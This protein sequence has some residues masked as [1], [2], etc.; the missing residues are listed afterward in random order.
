[1]I[2]SNLVPLNFFKS[3]VGCSINPALDIGQIEGAY[4][5]GLGW[6]MTE[7]IKHDPVT[8]QLLTAD[9]WVKYVKYIYIYFFFFCLL[10]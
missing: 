8:G 10:N 3:I 6:W 2:Q 9:T 5:F 4:V 7:Q 1:M